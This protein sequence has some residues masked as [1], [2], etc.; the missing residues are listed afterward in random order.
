MDAYCLLGWYLIIAVISF[1]PFLKLL[2]WSSKDKVVKFYD[3][4][5]TAS[6]SLL[7]VVTCVTLIITIILFAIVGLILALNEFRKEV[8]G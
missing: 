6:A 8:D 7:W 1:F 5:M 3:I 2:K 4:I